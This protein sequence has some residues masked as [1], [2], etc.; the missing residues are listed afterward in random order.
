MHLSREK[1]LSLWDLEDMPACET[2]MHLAEAFLLSCGEALD[3]F[4]EEEPEGRIAEI[5]ASYM[6]MVDHGDMCDDCKEAD[7]PKMPVS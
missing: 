3:R 4:G 7:M 1:L 5:T 6:A 2:G